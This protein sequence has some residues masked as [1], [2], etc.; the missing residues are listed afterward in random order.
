MNK[1]AF[2]SWPNIFLLEV[3]EKCQKYVDPPDHTDSELWVLGMFY[4][5]GALVPTKRSLNELPT[6]WQLWQ[7]SPCTSTHKEIFFI[8][9]VRKSHPARRLQHH[10]TPLWWTGTSTVCQTSP[11]LLCPTGMFMV[12]EW[13]VTINHICVSLQNFGHVLVCNFTSCYRT[14]SG[15]FSDKQFIDNITTWTKLILLL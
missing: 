10:P 5:F 1:T 15:N 9:F 3:D 2:K 13:L 12:F 7:C 14:F 11:M 6:F 8:S 4:G